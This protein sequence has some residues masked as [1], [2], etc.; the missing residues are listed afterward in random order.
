M[1]RAQERPVRGMTLPQHFRGIDDTHESSA[2]RI[3]EIAI[4]SD[5][6]LFCD[7]CDSAHW[8]GLAEDEAKLL[9]VN[10]F[11]FLRIAAT[12]KSSTNHPTSTAAP[13]A[14]A[15]DEFFQEKPCGVSIP[16]WPATRSCIDS[17]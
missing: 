4:L 3:E 11:Q 10:A 9:R 1:T 12:T 16:A 6:S 14:S 8:A 7:E 17:A 15:M 2:K 13:E 5:G